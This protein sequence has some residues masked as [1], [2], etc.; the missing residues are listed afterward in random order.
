M[1]PRQERRAR[2]ESLFRDVN[3]RIARVNQALA[4]TDYAEFV[5]ECDD[6][7][8]SER[9]EMSLRDYE[10]LRADPTTFVVVPG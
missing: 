1:D 8:C 4:V 3:E 2:N 9:F 7:G 5:C 10:R 6:L